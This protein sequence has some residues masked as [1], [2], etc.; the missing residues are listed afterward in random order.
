MLFRVLKFRPPER[1][2]PPEAPP[3]APSEATPE[4]VAAEPAASGRAGD[5]LRPVISRDTEFFWAGTAVRELRVQHCEDCGALRH[6]PGPRCTVCGSRRRGYRPVSGLGTIFSFVVHHHP[7]VSG[8]V[9]PFVVALVELPEGVRMLGELVGIDPLN[10]QDA[11]SVQV[12][13]PVEVV[14]QPVD[15]DLTL[16][17]WRLRGDR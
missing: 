17:A 12:G 4:P 2:S 1:P 16:P 6:P 13:A 9:A 7:P 10:P 5:P 14:W 8:R 3:E 15:D 11:A